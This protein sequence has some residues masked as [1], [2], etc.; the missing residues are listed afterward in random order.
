MKNLVREEKG[1]ALIIAL[2]LLLIGGLISAALLN[3]MGSGILAGVVHERRTAEL[4]AADAGVEDALWKIQHRDEDAAGYLP[5]SPGSPP[6][7]YT[8]TDVNGRNVQVTIEFADWSTYNITSIAATDGDGG[9]GVAAIDGTTAVEARAKIEYTDFSGLLDNAITSGDDITIRGNKTGVSGNI[10]LPPDGEL[11]PSDFDPENGEVKREELL[12]PSAKD[13][14][15]FYWPEVEYLTPVP[16][17]YEIDIPSGTS[18]ENPHVIESLSAAGDLTIKGNGWIEIGGTIYVKGD[19]VFKA[20]PTINM[21]LNQQTIFAE[22]GIYIPPQ[23]NVSGS[24]CIIAVGDVQFN[25]NTSS[26][27]EDFLLIMSVEGTIQLNPGSDFYGSIVG[28]IDVTL[29]PGIELTW[30]NPKGKGINFPGMDPSDSS[31]WTWKIDTWEVI[32]Q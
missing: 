23:V 18:E 12:W 29:Q 9:G 28:N 20:N 7:I 19:L 27:N 30:V 32:Q 10:S 15:D 17:G 4:Y 31:K 5:C 8:I 26:G 25:P 16:D 3:H 1:A 2:I 22:G 24:G 11:D 14:V 6:R 21:N 13:F